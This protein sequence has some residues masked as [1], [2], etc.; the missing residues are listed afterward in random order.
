MKN[1]KAEQ[2][3]VISIFKSICKFMAKDNV[4]DTL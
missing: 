2:M 1:E 4:K 3:F